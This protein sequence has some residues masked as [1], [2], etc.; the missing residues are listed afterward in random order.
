VLPALEANPPRSIRDRLGGLPGEPS[1]YPL[2]WQFLVAELV[3][4]LSLL[5][6]PRLL[7]ALPAPE[8]TD[9]L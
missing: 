4:P 3:H 7:R 5:Y 6:S 1:S 2:P 8:F 9:Y